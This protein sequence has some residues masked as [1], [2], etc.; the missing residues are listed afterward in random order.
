MRTWNRIL[1]ILLIVGLLGAMMPARAATIAPNPG[2]DKAFWRF[3]SPKPRPDFNNLIP[4]G[5]T[6]RS[7]DQPAPLVWLIA[8]WLF[9]VVF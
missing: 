6:T 7:V 9:G 3:M 2:Q 5:A 1:L 4:V 8:Y